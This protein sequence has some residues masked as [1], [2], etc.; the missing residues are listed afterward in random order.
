MRIS[1][2]AMISYLS[3]SQWT[4]RKLDKKATAEVAANHGNVEGWG[5]YNKVLIAEETLKN[6]AVV[7]NAARTY[8]Y[9]NTLPWD[10]RGGRILP[11]AHY[12]E[13]SAKMREFKDA[14]FSQVSTLLDNYTALC[15][16]AQSF[17]NGLYNPDDY[18]AIHKVERKYAFEIEIL[19]IPEGNDF[20]VSLDADQ[21]A[22]IQAT[23]ETR[24]K[25]TTENAMRDLWGR[26]HSAVSHMAD[27][28]GTPDAIFRASLVENVQDICKLLPKLNITNDPD[29][30]ALTAEV[31]CKL[32][33]QCANNLRENPDL[34]AKTAAEA[35]AIIDKMGAFM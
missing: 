23:I 34:R 3:V 9:E 25:T 21:T 14:F 11:A 7:A 19:P 5:R 1:E 20:R 12:L 8:H 29:L 17:L 26:L 35:K 16:Q 6:I 27:R 4:A 22:A 18:P 33:A 10:D 15:Q 28:L 32:T 13:Y 30:A 24:I 31:E 2:R